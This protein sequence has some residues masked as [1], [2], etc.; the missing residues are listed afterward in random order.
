[1]E[2]VSFPKIPRL[3]REIIVTEKIDGT[4]GCIFVGDESLGQPPF[5]VG[6]RSQWITP[7][8]T[9]DNHG[10][11]EWAYAHRDELV[12]GLGVGTHHGEWW[13]HGIQR[14]Y[15]RPDKRFSLFNVTRWQDAN[16]R[17]ACCGCV[18][19][20][21]RGMMSMG[22]AAMLAIES[23]KMQGSYAAPGFMNPE[24]II[25]FHT[26]GNLM[27]KKTILK[28]EEWKGKEP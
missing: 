15:G 22:E 10:F 4:N 1:M 8:K 17:P 27:F 12:A 14:N 18:P 20:I 24:G 28:D 6:S 16:V 26:A 9:T 3:S 5:L 2:F 19:V 11:A 23:L 13:G 25:I 7:G 21:L